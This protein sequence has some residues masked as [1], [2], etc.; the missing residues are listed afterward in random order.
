MAQE[1]EFPIEQDYDRNIEGI[2]TM[3]E[4]PEG[5][6]EVEMEPDNTTIE[7]QEDGS[8]VVTIDDEGVGPM[9]DE[10]FY[11]NLADTIEVW[12]M[13]SIAMKYLDFIEKDKEARE[14]RDKQYEEGIRRA[15]VG[16]DAPG[17]A[18]FQGASRVVH[19]VMA[20][21]CV[22]FASNAIRELFPV[23]G[24]VRTNIQGEA[25]DD[26]LERAERK[27]DFMNWQLVY[28]IPEF[29]DEEE[30]LLTQLPL[31]GSQFLKLWYDELQHRPRAEF[32][33]IDNILLPFASTNF[34]TSQRVTEV[35]DITQEE[36]ENRVKAGLY[37]DTNFVRATQ[38]PEQTKSQQA[39]DKVEGKQWQDNIDGVRRVFH[40]Y[41][42]LELEDDHYS[43]GERAPYILMIDDLNREVLGIY[44]NWEDGDESMTKLDW[45]IEF[46]FIPWRGAYAIGLPHLIGG[47]SAALTGALRALLDTAHI[48]NSAT[49]LKLKGAKISGQSDEIEVTQVVEIEGAPGVDDIKKIAMP[50]PFNPPSQVLFELL[51]WLD[52]AAK[53]VVTTAEEKIADATNQMPVGTTQALI[54]QGSKVASAI[55]ARIHD[56][57]RRVLQVLGR[58]NRWY[59]EDMQKGDEVSDLPIT[60]DDFA[61]NSDVLPISDPNIFSETQRMAQTQAVLQLATQ[62]PQLFDMRAV[63]TRMLKQMKIP[64]I[65]ELMP[66]VI[67][68]VE[69]DAAHENAAMALGKP[70]FAYPRQ[71][72][73]GHIQSHLSFA[74]DPNLGSSMIMAPALI[75]QVLEHLK[76]HLTL[77]YTNQMT[78]YATTGNNV[79]LHN[80]AN[81]ELTAEIDKVIALASQHVQLDSQQTFAK[82]QPAIG[83]LLQLMQQLAPKPQM[84]GAD[85]AL[86][87]ASMAETQRKAAKDQ[88]DGQLAV[89]K[90]QD[91][92]QREILRLQFDAS[93]AEKNRQADFGINAQNNLTQERMK[94]ADLTVDELKLRQ[95]QE[96]TVA[97]LN[98][99][100]QHNIGGSDGNNGQRPTE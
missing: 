29:K 23:D 31:G 88:Q 32:V 24:P 80:Y 43:G 81:M 86:L 14:E 71:D 37:R 84:D 11:S 97:E 44:R 5:G 83:Q 51:G 60:T 79:N 66:S 9:E 85:Q 50:L 70:A 26:K 67:K 1:P 34:Y 87:Q 28:Q 42:Y 6:L 93:E 17:G 72:H 73:L 78:E 94:T 7:E 74:L 30:Q 56:A 95:E 45:I 2:P 98:K 47:L 92:N 100:I 99:E 52:T 19:P 21:A 54:E 20:E 62:F 89:A 58:I 8:A 64:A 75:P 15:G 4:T 63:M 90:Q 61:K 82:V 77:W 68:P 36:F 18:N 13:G 27:A 40:I 55:H 76:Q 49:M 48:N 25:T 12:N 46:K 33:P 53:G 16:N 96:T 65:D 3:Q 69:M 38:E 91:E 39:T 22:D 10:D 35:H 57:Q 59:L 41:T